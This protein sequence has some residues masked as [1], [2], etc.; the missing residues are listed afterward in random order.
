MC[1]QCPRQQNVILSEAKNLTAM[2]TVVMTVKYF[3]D[4]LSE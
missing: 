2:S 1:V 4:G 3:S